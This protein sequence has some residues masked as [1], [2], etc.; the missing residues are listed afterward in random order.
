MGKFNDLTGLRFG[1]LKVNSLVIHKYPQKWSCECDCGK[2]VVVTSPSLRSGNTKSC[3]CL[4]IELLKGRTIKHGMCNTKEHRAWK[5]MK[6]RCYNPRSQEYKNYGGRG[7]KVCESWRDS[8]EAFFKEI[9]YAPSPEH[10]LNRLDNNGNY[11]S[12]NVNWATETEQQ[13]NTRRTRLIEYRGETRSMIEW[14]EFLGLNY[15]RVRTR[16]YS[17][18]IVERAFTNEIFKR[19]KRK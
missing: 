5:D 4:A 9:G 8:F 14:C 7:V 6:A 18:M 13:R 1:R 12:G 17:G 11:E 2:I 3:G 16:I 10:S 19:V 15:K